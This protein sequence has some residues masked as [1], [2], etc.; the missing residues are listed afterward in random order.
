[1]K[2]LLF[3]NTLMCVGCGS[4]FEYEYLDA[5]VLCELSTNNGYV[6]AGSTSKYVRRDASYDTMC[7]KRF[8]SKENVTVKK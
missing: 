8:S 3:L 4:D 1:M 5:G 6:I 7:D 2:K